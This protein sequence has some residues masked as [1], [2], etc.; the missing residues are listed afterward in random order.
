[1]A[2]TRPT[3][4]KASRFPFHGCRPAALAAAFGVIVV[5]LAC[6]PGVLRAAEADPARGMRRDY[7]KCEVQVAVRD[8]RF[9]IESIEAIHFTPS[10]RFLHTTPR[11]T[12]AAVKARIMADLNQLM[13]LDLPVSM[14]SRNKA[15]IGT[16]VRADPRPAVTVLAGRLSWAEARAKLSD[17]KFLTEALTTIVTSDYFVSALKSNTSLRYYDDATRTGEIVTKRSSG[18]LVFW[19]VDPVTAADVQAGAIRFAD[20]EATYTH[21]KSRFGVAREDLAAPLRPLV[22]RLWNHR[23]IAVRL[24]DCYA[25][26]GMDIAEPVNL[27]RKV[28]V[29][30]TALLDRNA[31][32]EDLVPGAVLSGPWRE[33]LPENRYGLLG[34]EVQ[35][36]GRRQSRRIL[37]SEPLYVGQVSITLTPDMPNE[38]TWQLLHGVLNGS[39]WDKIREWKLDRLLEEPREPAEAGPVVKWF[40]VP[41]EKGVWPLSQRDLSRRARSLAP[42]GYSTTLMEAATKRAA[43]HLSP[44]PRKEVREAM[45]ETKSETVTGPTPP[46]ADEEEADEEA[47]EANAEEEEPGPAEPPE[48]A[49]AS[50]DKDKP[51]P[52]VVEREFRNYATAGATYRPGQGTDFDVTYGRILLP[53]R[54]ATG[55]IELGIFDELTGDLEFKKSYLGFGQLGRKLDVDLRIYSD[56]EP[57]RAAE[58]KMVDERRKGIEATGQLELLRARRGHWLSLDGGFTRERIKTEPE[59]GEYQTKAEFAFT[60]F[61][62]DPARI[63]APEIT[64]TGGGS[65]HWRGDRQFM[66]GEISGRAHGFLGSYLEFDVRAAVA[67]AEKGTPALEQPHFEEERAIRGYR[68]AA[69]YGLTAGAAQLELWVPLRWLAERFPSYEDRLR[70]Q[71]WAVFV[72]YGAFR[73]EAG[74]SDSLLGA[75]LGLRLRLGEGA[76]IALDGAYGFDEVAG[77]DGRAR[78]HTSI[79]MDFPF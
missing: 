28:E 29:A 35:D 16:Y 59:S 64:V 21:R 56:F 58:G 46:V 65:A 8:E 4:P 2:A 1:M 39:D 3:G 37:I 45:D 12:D 44:I 15:E 70:R 72:D 57:D 26:R 23:E 73:T 61:W 74:A 10:N 67:W 52:R 36:N 47:G 69:V 5:A 50:P 25:P 53:D 78:L 30:N 42:L 27:V 9:V 48:P 6:I 38:T 43:L 7:S 13:D 60:W 77:A 32:D 49:P 18:R 22:G 63:G 55:E 54:T 33:K 31:K 11:P 17:S 40:A 68:S 19:V 75:G 51:R 79:S 71:Y 24:A 66:L 41:R 34:V 20:A 14:W 62:H 76:A